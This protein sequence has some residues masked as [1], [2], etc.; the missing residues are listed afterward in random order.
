MAVP[1]AR[2]RRRAARARRGDVRGVGRPVPGHQRSRRPRRRP[3]RRRR[4]ARRR[5]HPAGDGRGHPRR[6][7]RARRG[8]GSGDAH[9]EPGG[10]GVLR[11]V[12]QA[13]VGARRGVAHLRRR[14]DR[15]PD[16]RGDLRRD[17]AAVVL[18]LPA[19][20]RAPHRPRSGRGGAV[21]PPRRRRVAALPAPARRAPDRVAGRAH[22][23]P[24]RHRRDACR[25]RQQPL[26]ARPAPAAR[27]R[28]PTR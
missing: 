3:A 15:T 4:G 10:A 28:S 21:R 23:L 13:R 27:R 6:G 2:R 24:R 5:V 18:A 9:R 11:P 8:R 20:P 14:G 22:R 7:R 17:P 12:H 16:V 1:R 25:A 19:Q 26:G